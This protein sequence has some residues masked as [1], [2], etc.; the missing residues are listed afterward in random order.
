M[1]EPIIDG[2]VYLKTWAALVALLLLT[3]GTAYLHLGRLNFVVAMLIAFAKA[4]LIVLVFMHI[5]WGSRLLRLAALAG[6]IWLAILLVQTLTD[7]ATRAGVRPAPSVPGTEAF[8]LSTPPSSTINAA[9]HTP[10]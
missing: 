7:Y 4:T 8:N 3:V 10:R 9:A 2:K 5:K 1:P 6:I